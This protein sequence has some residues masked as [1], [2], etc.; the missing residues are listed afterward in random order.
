[1]LQVT[2]LLTGVLLLGLWRSRAGWELALLFAGFF[3]IDWGYFAGSEILLRQQTIGK[4]ALRLRVVS[5]FG[6]TPDVSR[7]VVRN[8]T[9][10]VD[11]FVGVPAMALDPLARRLG[12][13]LAG[14]L[15]IHDEGRP[16]LVLHRIPEGWG[17]G[18]VATVESLLER[19]GEMEAWRV[20]RMARTVLE[21]LTSRHPDFLAGLPADL[22]PVE[23]LRRAFD[24]RTS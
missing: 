7:L 18:D 9:R 2:W 10:I 13:R 12:D 11:L 17:A 24:A 14:T 20:E 1:V 21:T 4:K 22:A 23:A 15:V 5:R 3:L 19:S 8:L 6:G 16:R